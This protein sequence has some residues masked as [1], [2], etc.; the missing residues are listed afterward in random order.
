VE[1]KEVLENI[2]TSTSGKV[3]KKFIRIGTLCG[4]VNSIVL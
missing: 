4:V 3:Q 2:Q 1:N